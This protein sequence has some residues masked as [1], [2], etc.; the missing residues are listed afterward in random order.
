MA[1]PTGMLAYIIAGREIRCGTVHAKCLLQYYCSNV[2]KDGKFFKSML[3]ICAETKL[4]RAFV[5]YT[6]DDWK[7]K[8]VLSWAEGDWR[9]KTANTYTLNLAILRKIA[10]DSQKACAE[11]KERERQQAAE[12]ARTYRERHKRHATR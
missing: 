10:S 12:R 7:K 9:K 8:G 2:N 6:N 4:S 11:S 1:E 5:A 3:D